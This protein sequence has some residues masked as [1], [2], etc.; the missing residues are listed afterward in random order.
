ML[1]QPTSS[2]RSRGRALHSNARQP[3]LLPPAPLHL[4]LLRGASCHSCRRPQ[5]AARGVE[6]CS[7]DSGP[8]TARRP[9]SS[10]DEQQECT[11][12]S[13]APPPAPVISPP[14]LVREPRALPPVPD[15][16]GRPDGRDSRAHQL[17]IS[18]R[19]APSLSAAG[20]AQTPAEVP[21]SDQVAGERL[22]ARAQE[23]RG[24]RWGSPPLSARARLAELFERYSPLLPGDPRHRQV[25]HGAVNQFSKLL[26]AARR[27]RRGEAAAGAA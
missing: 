16:E 14:C 15:A 24:G 17:G 21:R 20:L 1:S 7:C 18:T 3:P 5:A 2:E 12:R 4:P 27:W 23:S 19:G 22:A 11:A 6:C 25:R 9:P 10:P 13:G 26:V 8:V